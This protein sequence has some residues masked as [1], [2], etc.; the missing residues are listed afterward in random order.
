[1]PRFTILELTD[2]DL[3]VLQ[4]T[5]RKKEGFA[6]DRVQTV[7][8]GDLPRDESGD[9][10]RTERIR[11]K[12]KGL[13]GGGPSETAL[14]VPK[15]HCVARL[16]RLPSGNPAEI[17]EM[18]HFEAEKFIPF[19]VEQH[20]I[21]HELVR[22]DEL[23]G[24][25][26]FL[27]AVDG[28]YITRCVEI[29]AATGLDP[30]FANVTAVSLAQGALDAIPGLGAEEPVSIVH[31]GRVHVEVATIYQ[32]LV[33]TMRA[34]NHGLEALAKAVGEKAPMTDGSDGIRAPKK[35]H[36]HDLLR[37]DFRDP[38]AFER[39]LNPG[40]PETGRTPAG[41]AARRW[42]AVLATNFR[43][44]H[45]FA[46]RERPVPTIR[47]ILV[48]G[49]GA[50]ITFLPEAV[51]VALGVEVELF[52]PLRALPRAAGFQAARP[53]QFLPYAPA[54]GALNRLR[55]LAELEDKA[56]SRV[57]LL[58]P[59]VIER[60]AAQQRRL[61]L[62]I[63]ATLLIVAA[64]LGSLLFMSQSSLRQKQE[65]SYAEAIRLMRPHVESIAE[66]RRKVE[67]IERIR[68]ERSSALSLLN[69]ISAYPMVRPVP[70][71]GTLTL[72]DFRFEAGKDVEISGK[73]LS[74]EDIN[75]F[76]A[77]LR[78]IEEGGRPAFVQGSLDGVRVASQ[79]PTRLIGRE[80][81]MY[82][83]KIVGPLNIPDRR[84]R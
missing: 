70:D 14:L 1:M 44:N 28:P 33:V 65:E 80:Q 78:S 77:Y 59:E 72:S 54:F 57:N 4:A 82:E 76:V 12:L 61:L 73:A 17:A 24:S 16:V 35:V 40:G 49:D 3:K 15:Q 21:A 42:L 32:G 81:Q 55:E 47:K 46:Q 56:P 53:T 45:E 37:L 66:K 27:A 79:T 31:I 30:L 48:C 8:F 60:Q 5:W 58:P 26:V 71:G 25:D 69:Q 22:S 74:I 10:A 62:M 68:S 84:S 38:D 2:A 67:I 13:D 11:E 43:R 9:A 6:I 41:E 83:F 18:A 52:D 7:E 19:N 50:E 63:T 23:N 36:P 39:V 20:V 75:A 29:A 51:G 64:A 34:F